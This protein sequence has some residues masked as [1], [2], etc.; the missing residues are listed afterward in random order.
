MVAN[1]KW[2]GG[3]SG[4]FYEHEL[5]YSLSTNGGEYLSR[6]ELGNKK[7]WTLSVWIKTRGKTFFG[8]LWSNAGSGHAGGADIEY[9][10]LSD[11]IIYHY[12]NINGSVQFNCQTRNRIRDNMNWTH[13]VIVKDTAQSTSSD[14]LKYYVNGTQ[15]TEFSSASYPSQDNNSGYINSGQ[16]EV[17]FHEASRWRYPTYMYVS[18]F[19]FSDG[20]AYAP[21]E[22]GELKEGVWI[23]K[24]V[25]INYGTTGWH[26]D[27]ADSSNV[28]ND[29][30]GNNNDWSSSGFSAHDRKIDNPTNNFATLNEHLTQYQTTSFNDGSLTCTGSGSSGSAT[31]RVGTAT[32]ACHTKTYF[33][34]RIASKSGNGRNG[35]GL[36]SENTAI[37]TYGSLSTAMT[38][39]QVSQPHGTNQ[40]RQEDATVSTSGEVADTGDIVQWAFDPDSGKV[41]HGVNNT[42]SLSGDPANGNNP[43]VTLTTDEFM[44]PAYHLQASSDSLNFNFGQNPSF[45]G[46]L[47]GGDIGTE[48]DENGFGL[49]KYAV[50]S[51]F[52]ALCS[53]NIPSPDISPDKSDKANDFF[54]PTLYTSDNIGASGTQNVT[55][56]NFQ[57]DL[58]WLK[59]RDSGSTTNTLF[60]SSRGTGKHISSDANSAEVGSNSQYGYLSAFNSNGFT[61][62]GGSTN[63][64]YVNQSTDKYVA[65]NW[66]AN[67][68]ST[69]TND[70]S[71]SGVG[72][73]DSTYQAN[74]SAGFSIV[75]YV[76]TGSAGTIAHGLS[77]A[78]QVVLIKNRTDAREF[79]FGHIG[80]TF[81]G[82]TYL[83]TGGA[84][85]ANTGSFNGTAPTSTVVS[86]G[87]DQTTNE[88]GD[89]MIM[90]CWHSVYG[91]SR[92]GSYEGNGNSTTG[93]FVYTG[94]SP[95][96][97]VTKQV[98]GGNFYVNDSARSTYNPTNTSA[99]N[100]YWDLAN[101]ESGNGMDFLSN[102]FLIRN[103]DS[104]QNTNNSAYVY[105]AWALLPF[106]FS[107]GRT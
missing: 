23:P 10:G 14:R 75:Q 25:S 58:V 81:A 103:S 56:V 57:P 7:L 97:V 72:T 61:L 52:L 76:G 64:N 42:W 55:N 80:Q 30:S 89:N 104:S 90:Y 96:L 79:V 77:S 105:M 107:N 85:G 33:E 49:F 48:T 31:Y 88:S 11:G 86:V 20:Y 87:G 26:L 84:Y 73:I 9:I 82:Q 67:G 102:G 83:S 22:F 13:L 32:M 78:P 47:T 93:T 70:A 24:E 3:G 98:S 66:K 92:M 5:N 101:A 95:S 45:S 37:D 16:T 51:G 53:R 12:Q 19:H 36:L 54:E 21:T 18:E 15:V 74:T 34:V 39:V 94:F 100:L 6:A 8:E 60:D 46:N 50:P 38:G 35:S 2:F 41:W 40:I 29:V 27:F 68:G 59:N 1:E 71:Y 91:F 4:D 69:T 63:A 62:T 65:W 44:L 28:G 43:S 99:G 106:K 17:L